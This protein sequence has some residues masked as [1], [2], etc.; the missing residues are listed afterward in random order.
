[1]IAL[2]ALLSSTPAHALELRFWGVGPT[3]GTMLFPGAYPLAAPSNVDTADGGL[4]IEKVRGDVEIGVRGIL[5]PGPKGR[6]SARFD[7]GFG[8]NGFS[9]N[10]FVVGYDKVAW[11]DE[12]LQVLVGGG[13]GVG[14]ETFPQKD[15]GD[16]YLDVSYY[17]LRAEA[18]ALLRLGDQ[19]VEVGAHADF[20]LVSQQP[21]YRNSDDEDPLPGSAGSSIGLSGAAYLGV[22]VEATYYFGDFTPP[23]QDKPKKHKDKKKG[24]GGKGKK[25]R[26]RG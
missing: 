21:W 25:N 9:R 18:S 3:M 15:D 24:R 7:H 19:A 1:M 10:E 12:E 17:P 6:L 26:D 22:A 2:L 5:Y 13:A 8:T 23:G 16:G 20:H 4:K 11:R 14:G